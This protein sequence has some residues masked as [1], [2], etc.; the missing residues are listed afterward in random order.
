MELDPMGQRLSKPSVQTVGI[1][2]SAPMFRV[3]GSPPAPALGSQR[4]SCGGAGQAVLAGPPGSGE[5]L[6]QAQGS[7]VKALVSLI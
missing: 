5:H 4:T 7:A 3:S 1:C 6:P 2:I